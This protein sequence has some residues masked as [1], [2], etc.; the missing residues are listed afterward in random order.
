MLLE[1]GLLWYEDKRPI[2]HFMKSILW[3]KLI[4][5]IMKDEHEKNFHSELS[6]TY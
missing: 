5:L 2:P 6:S 4:E 1:E 3:N